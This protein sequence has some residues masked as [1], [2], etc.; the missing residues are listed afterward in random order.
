MGPPPLHPAPRPPPPPLVIHPPLITR[1][2]RPDPPPLLSG[3]HFYLDPEISYIP[4]INKNGVGRALV[5]APLV[6]VSR[7]LKSSRPKNN[8]AT[9]ADKTAGR[10]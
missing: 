4:N 6:F 5:R 10:Y 3:G 9:P 2:A 1:H 7:S 8:L